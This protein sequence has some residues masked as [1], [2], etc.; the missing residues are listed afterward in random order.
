MNLQNDG[1][2]I[3]NTEQKS[4]KRKKLKKA[5]IIIGIILL[6]LVI[7]AV[8]AFAVMYHIG[9]KQ[10]LENKPQTD[11]SDFEE[12]DDTVVEHNG[13]KYKYNDNITSILFIGVD[14]NSIKTE[15]DNYGTNGQAD[16]VYLMA[17]D[18]STGKTDV[19]GISRDSMTDVSLYSKE[20]KYIGTEKM[21]LCLAYAYGDRRHSS[22]N[23]V[24]QSVSR[25]FYGIPINT[26]FAIDLSGISP[27]VKAV[28]GFT[29]NEYDVNN[30]VIGTKQINSSNALQFVRSR[31]KTVLDSNISRMSNQQEFLKAF[32]A[33][34]TQKTKQDLSVPVQL[35]N[36]VTDYSVTNINASKI[37]YLASK[38]I[39]ANT[40]ISFHTVQGQV[41]QGEYAEFHVNTDALYNLLLDIFY[42]KQ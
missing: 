10:L 9:K 15:S 19:I 35:Y 6:C 25:M 39:N 24:V 18:T 28:G 22:C 7:T 3:V 11:A 27:L 37:T 17:I 20:G 34:A 30:N 31:D 2:E 21:Q 40:S 33:K 32:A 29:V 36:V 12:F 8:S 13:V 4:P 1:V 42:I 5:L 41:V 14:E 26:Y 23:N 16:A 38:Y